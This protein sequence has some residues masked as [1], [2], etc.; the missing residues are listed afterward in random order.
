LHLGGD[1]PEERAALLTEI[2]KFISDHSADG[3]GLVDALNFVAY[4]DWIPAD[5]TESLLGATEKKSDYLNYNPRAFFLLTRATIE[6]GKAQQIA[7]WRKII[8]K[9]SG[10]HESYDAR[11][12]LFSTVKDLAER[13]KLYGQLAEKDPDDASLPVA[14]ARAYLDAKQKLPEALLLLD[15]AEKLIDE[16]STPKNGQRYYPPDSVK[17]WKATVAVTR[18]GILVEMGRP[19]DALAILLPREH[20]FKLAS[21]YYLLGRALEATGDNRAAIDAYLEA[22]VRPWGDQQRASDALE[23]LWLGEKMGSKKELQ[24]H[25]EDAAAHDFADAGYEPHLLQHPAPNF[26]LTTLRG[27]HFSNTQLKGKIVVLN[28]WAVWCGPC[29]SELNP[30]QDLQHKHLEVVVLTVVNT[31]TDAKQLKDVIHEKKLTTLRIS[32]ASHGLWQQ[33]GA[34]GVPNTFIIDKNGNIR[35]QHVGGIPDVSRY[36][37]ADISA[38]AEATP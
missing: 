30:L 33:L 2:S 7:L 36:L 18:A 10:T 9:Y 22:A 37:T 13:E 19:G 26:D 5:T 21:S 34:Y 14:M 6:K 15:R 35:T 4:E 38:I 16:H 29:L 27:E 32:P 12:S 20:E 31:D 28:L 25:M 23:Q 1:T 17:V 8:E 11:L 3:F 24:R